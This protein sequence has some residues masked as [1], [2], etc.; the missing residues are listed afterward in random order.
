MQKSQE[1]VKKTAMSFNTRGR[2]KRQ[3]G[4]SSFL[5][6]ASMAQTGTAVSAT[7]A[8]LKCVARHCDTLEPTPNNALVH[9]I[10]SIKSLFRSEKLEHFKMML[11]V[12]F[13]YRCLIVFFQTGV[14]STTFNFEDSTAH[15]SS[16]LAGSIRSPLLKSSIHA[17]NAGV[18]K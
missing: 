4:H 5:S 11:P 1:R 9:A 16:R 13:P 17:D 15:A 8:K 2:Q 10:V 14:C 12:F 3:R 18:E 7:L 6:A